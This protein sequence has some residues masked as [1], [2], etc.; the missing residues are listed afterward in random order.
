[1]QG[2]T[3]RKWMD[4]RFVGRHGTARRQAI[5]GGRVHPGRGASSPRGDTHRKVAPLRGGDVGDLRPGERQTGAEPSNREREHRR[6]SGLGRGGLGGGST[7]SSTTCRPAWKRSRC[8][9]GRFAMRS[10]RAPRRAW[11]R[12][13]WARFRPRPSNAKPPCAYRRSMGNRPAS[14]AATRAATDSGRAVGRCRGGLARAVSMLQDMEGAARRLDLRLASG[15]ADVLER[16]IEP[17]ARRLSGT[18][19]DIDRRLARLEGW[20]EG[21]RAGRGAPERP[22]QGSR[23]DAA[24]G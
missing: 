9:I 20:I 2:A 24:T 14:L 11:G 23:G 5:P 19:A 3:G 7:R 1:M 18:V 6:R 22:R 13:Y 21:E 16:A 12:P 8:G 17:R 10:R 15:V 4:L